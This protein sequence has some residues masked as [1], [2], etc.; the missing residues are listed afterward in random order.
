MLSVKYRQES[1]ET[2]FTCRMTIMLD[3]DA[4]AVA[5]GTLLAKTSTPASI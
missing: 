1:D 4:V 3:A 5:V 2:T